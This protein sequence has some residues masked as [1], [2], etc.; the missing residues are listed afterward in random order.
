[1]M[2]VNRHQRIWLSTPDS[3]TNGPAPCTMPCMASQETI[4]VT[5]A[6]PS[7]PKR[8]APHIAKGN[9]DKAT[10]KWSSPANFGL[11]KIAWPISVK[12]MTRVRAS[13]VFVN[14]AEV[15]KA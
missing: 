10:G 9:R 14:D 2:S 13:R 11:P 8:S 5:V 7:E 6:A 12:E 3:T 1:M 15:G 4:S